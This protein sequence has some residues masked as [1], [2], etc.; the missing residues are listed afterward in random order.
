MIK[1]IL[2]EKEN[3]KDVIDFYDEFKNNNDTCIGYNN[4][5]NYKEWLQ[6]MQNRKNNVNLKKG[7]VKENFYLCYENDVLVG[8]FS[9]KFELTDYLLNYGGHIGYAVRPTMRNR[10]IATRILSQGIDI[11]IGLGINK[12]LLVCDEDNYASE[13]VILNNDGKFENKL[14]DEEEQVYVKRY[15][16]VKEK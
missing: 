6:E 8:V 4:Y 13:K 11:A 1:F 10:G 5:S 16:I 3:E 2:P 9:L 12:L 14:F 15:W 7:Y